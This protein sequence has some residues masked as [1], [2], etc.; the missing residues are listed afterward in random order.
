M[1]G[2]RPLSWNPHGRPLTQD[3]Y[4]SVPS[5]LTETQG[6][7]SNHLYY[8]KLHGSMNW[9]SSDGQGLMVIGGGKRA[10][11][12]REKLLHSY[13]KLFEDVLSRRNRRLLV[14]GYGFR[15]SHINEV[16]AHAIR[17]YGLKL[18]AISPASPRDFRATLLEDYDKDKKTL[19]DQKTLED[20]RTLWEGLAGY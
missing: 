16:I 3:D 13:S 9:L 20:K 10:Q 5:T 12:Q 17:K 14:I 1:P 15:D 8:I 19:E 2:I 18:S 6:S 4:V 7:I 11:I